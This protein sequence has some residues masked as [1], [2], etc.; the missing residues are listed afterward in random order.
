MIAFLLV[1]TSF[2]TNIRVGGDSRRHG[3]YQYNGLS[4][5]IEATKEGEVETCWRHQMKI[6]SALLAFCEGNPPVNGGFPSQRSVTRR[7]DVFFDLCLN[8][9]V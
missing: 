8:K 6:F 7:S 1:G 4:C 2:W 5:D 9:P 3:G